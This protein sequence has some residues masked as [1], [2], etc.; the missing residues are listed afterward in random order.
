VVL[1]CKCWQHQLY[2]HLE[3]IWKFHR[4][5]PETIFANPSQNLPEILGNM[6]QS[7][8]CWMLRSLG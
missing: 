8:R 3:D 5:N 1:L 2:L 6:P 7:W 4:K